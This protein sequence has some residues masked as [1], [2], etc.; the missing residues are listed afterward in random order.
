MLDFELFE[1]FYFFCPVC[2]EKSYGEPVAKTFPPGRHERVYRVLQQIPEWQEIPEDDEMDVSDL[3]FVP[4]ALQC[5][6]CGAVILNEVDDI[7]SEEGFEKFI[8]SLEEMVEMEGGN[9]DDR[10]DDW[11]RG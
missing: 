11:W 7:D 8:K 9:D 2:S 10:G 3:K 1:A 5:E 4:D 6:S